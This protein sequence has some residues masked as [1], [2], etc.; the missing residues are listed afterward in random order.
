MNR[1]LIIAMAATGLV[2]AGPVAA[3][4]NSPMSDDLDT[5]I[6]EDALEQHNDIVEDVLEMGVAT[7]EGG[8]E[9]GAFTGSY[10][11]D[12]ADGPDD[13]V[14]GNDA[15]EGYGMVREPTLD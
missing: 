8:S 2:L 6:P 15:M 9:M 10:E 1:A 13:E 11:M 12:P 14:Y 4:H 7:M 3:H 5:I